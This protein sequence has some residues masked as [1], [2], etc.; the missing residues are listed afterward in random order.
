M[1]IHLDVYLGVLCILVN[2]KES[3][4]NKVFL[5]GT[6]EPLRGFEGI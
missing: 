3:G 6:L 1:V 4:L 2:G 5:F